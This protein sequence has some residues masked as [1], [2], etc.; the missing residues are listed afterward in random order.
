[1][2]LLVITEYLRDPGFNGSEVFARDLIQ[3]LGERHHVDVLARSTPDALP[4]VRYLVDK[5][6]Y[7]D[8][9][10]LQAFLKLEVDLDAYD[11]IYNL[12]ALAFG[13][14]TSLYLLEQ[15]RTTPLVNHF[16]VLLTHYAKKERLPVAEQESQ[17]DSQIEAAKAGTLNIFASQDEARTARRL[18]FVSDRSR[19]AV[20]PNGLDFSRIEANG[21][22]PFSMPS[23]FKT[24]PVIVL[25]AGRLQDYVK[26][27]D[28]VCRA[29]VRLCQDRDDVYLVSIGDS[30]RFSYLLDVLPGDRYALLDWL[31]RNQFAAAIAHC[32][33]VVVPSRY[34]PFGLIAVESMALGKPVVANDTGGLSEIVHHGETGLLNPL[35]NGSLGLYLA[36]KRMAE[37]TD[38]AREMGLAGQSFVRKEYSI[39]RVVELVER[40]LHRATLSHRLLEPDLAVI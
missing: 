32:D 5:D 19:V 11:V 6:V 20:A 7:A 31:P 40:Q 26:G 25:T 13:C 29:F 38:R 12:G 18:E 1:M 22:S 33:F 28:L 39:D 37:D 34:E 4:G 27:A 35:R 15:N 30:T 2:N 17:R 14:C 3:L 23:N 9:E 21:P 10:K 24:P 16:Q 8:P 36:M